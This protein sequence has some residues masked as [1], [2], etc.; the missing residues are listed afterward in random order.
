[1]LIIMN[2]DAQ[3][4]DVDRLREAEDVGAQAVLIVM[5]TPGGLMTPWR[6]SSSRSSPRGFRESWHMG[7]PTGIQSARTLPSGTHS[8]LKVIRGT[9]CP[10]DAGES[11]IWP[12]EVINGRLERFETNGNMHCCA[13]CAGWTD[14]MG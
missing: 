9:Q 12:S 6:T 4:A 8:L 5:D 1:M 3:R 14:G 11:G 7:L 10:G 2:R 13:G